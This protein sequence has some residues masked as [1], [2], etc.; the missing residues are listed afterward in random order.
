MIESDGTGIALSVSLAGL[1]E[2]AILQ[3]T[4]PADY[5]QVSLIQLLESVF[6]ENEADCLVVE[7]LLDVAE[8]PDLPDIYDCFLPIFDQYRSG[9]CRLKLTTAAGHQTRLSDITLDHLQPVSAGSGDGPALWGLELTIEPEY[10]ALDYAAA[11]GYGGDREELLTWLRSCTLLYF[12]DQHEYRL[13]AWEAMTENDPLW[14]IVASLFQRGLLHSS[15]Q[16]G[17]SEI[18]P[19]GRRFIHALLSET[20]ACIDR[21][22]RFKDT[23]WDED[24]GAA[25][26]DTGYGDDL[27]VQ[28][29]IA[30]GLDPVRTVFLL[31]LYDGTLDEFAS[32][33]PELIGDTDFFNRILEPVVNRCQVPEELLQ[34]IV[35][36]G[37]AGLEAWAESAR[38]ER[39]QASI[40]RQVRYLDGCR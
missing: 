1:P 5:S 36:D 7:E 10:Q 6:P 37:Y 17:Y 35:E 9:L 14:P 39:F 30:E 34:E 15:G 27:R 24:T 16:T 22:D 32:T 31:R 19:E 8:N 11:Q 2:D 25:E 40:A 21:F 38:E 12:L 3:L 4:L 28:V 26:F 33:W 23:F 20:E 18:A 13:P 29:F